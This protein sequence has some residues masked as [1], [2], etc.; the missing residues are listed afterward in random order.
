MPVTLTSQELSDYQLHHEFRES[1]LGF[2][3]DYKKIQAV[4][5]FY[6]QYRYIPV[7]EDNDFQKFL[8]SG[9]GWTKKDTVGC[10]AHS[11]EC[12]KIFDDNLALQRQQKIK[13]FEKNWAQEVTLLEER[14]RTFYRMM[15]QGGENEVDPL[16]DQS[17]E[18]S[19]AEIISDNTHQKD[20]SSSPTP[21]PISKK[22][23]VEE[24]LPKDKEREEQK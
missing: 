12:L 14:K 7:E 19:S 18:K 10:L 3:K 15:G 9:D 24:Y 23:K 2:Y 4:Q 20:V 6:A 8:D 11:K 5:K 17:Q 21:S 16:T 22:R 1:V 13:E